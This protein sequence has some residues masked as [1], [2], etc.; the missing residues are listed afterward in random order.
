LED[1]DGLS[2]MTKIAARRMIAAARDDDWR[3]QKNSARET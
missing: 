1:E 2:G 3:A